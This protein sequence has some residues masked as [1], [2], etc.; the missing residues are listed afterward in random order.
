M[1]SNTHVLLFIFCLKEQIKLAQSKQKLIKRNSFMATV[2]SL[3]MIT[4]LYLSNINH[5]GQ[6]G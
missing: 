1:E 5:Q 2:P 6:T 4:M 3:R